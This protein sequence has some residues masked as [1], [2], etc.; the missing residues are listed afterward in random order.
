MY[1]G[2]NKSIARDILFASLL[3]GVRDGI[4]LGPDIV[5][6]IIMRWKD[7]VLPKKF[8]LFNR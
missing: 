2:V 1:E 7:S 6:P 3:G 5:I 4:Y 8:S